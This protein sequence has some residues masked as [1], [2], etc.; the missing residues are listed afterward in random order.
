ML[1]IESAKSSC[2]DVACKLEYVI[3]LPPRRW[4]SGTTKGKIERVR[5]TSLFLWGSQEACY[6][7][8]AKI[9]YLWDRGWAE[10]LVQSVIPG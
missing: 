5:G 4:A 1:S 9:R 2:Q 8:I 10:G 3:L 6:A 7:D